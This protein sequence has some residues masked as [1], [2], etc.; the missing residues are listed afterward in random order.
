LLQGRTYLRERGC[1][2]DRLILE[3][4]AVTGTDLP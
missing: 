1:Y 2:R 4:E 3:M